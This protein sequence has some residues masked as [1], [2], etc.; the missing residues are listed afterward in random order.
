MDVSTRKVKQVLE[1]MGGVGTG[2]ALFEMMRGRDRR[3]FFEDDYLRGVTACAGR[4]RGKFPRF[5]VV[6]R[7]EA[8]GFAVA[9]N[10]FLL[11]VPLD[12]AFREIGDVAEMCDR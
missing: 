11:R 4:S 9:G 12:L 6:G 5:A 1:K 8:V 2:F 3:D 10:A 7:D